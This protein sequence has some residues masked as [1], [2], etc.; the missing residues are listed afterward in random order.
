ME[1]TTAA[2]AAAPP[3][4]SLGSEI[5]R[6]DWVH[7]EAYIRFTR[8]T[9]RRHVP[10]IARQRREAWLATGGGITL[11]AVFWTKLA[12]DDHSIRAAKWL[13]AAA[14]LTSASVVVLLF[15]FYLAGSKWLRLMRD[16]GRLGGRVSLVFG[17]DAVAV[18]GPRS[19]GLVLW[20]AFEAFIITPDALLLR[21]T[22][23]DGTLCVPLGNLSAPDAVPRLKARFDESRV[24]ASGSRLPA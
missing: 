7:D 9:V 6:A 20:S 13:V 2:P 10:R 12:E 3:S 24:G 23:E 18:A 15:S 16:P 1:S 22:G 5:A 19:T 21:F 17:E 11:A 8:A 4:I 14:V